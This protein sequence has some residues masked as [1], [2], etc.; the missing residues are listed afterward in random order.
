MA[1]IRPVGARRKIKGATIVYVGSL[2]SEA[3]CSRGHSPARLR[4]S[5][6]QM[7]NSRLKCRDPMS[8]V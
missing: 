1:M 6:K 2:G 7:S 5:G 4:P 8:V 3:N